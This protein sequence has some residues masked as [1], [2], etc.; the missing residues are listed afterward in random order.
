MRRLLTLIFI[1][2]ALSAQMSGQIAIASVTATATQ[3]ILQYTSPVAQACRIQVADMNR[4]ITVASVSQAN[5]QVTIQTA[6]SWIAR[7]ISGF[8]GKFRRFEWLA[9]RDFG[10]V[11][12]EFGLFERGYQRR[13][14][15]QRGSFSRRCE[16]RS[17]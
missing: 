2:L 15:R 1:P 12:Y 11:Y 17:L 6:A 16:S 3:A 10:S 9:N 13:F 14:G 8:F 7:P 5:G 4:A